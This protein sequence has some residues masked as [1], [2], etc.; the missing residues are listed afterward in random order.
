MSSYREPS[1]GRCGTSIATGIGLHSAGLHDRVRGGSLAFCEPVELGVWTIAN[2][3]AGST[4]CARRAPVLGWPLVTAGDTAEQLANAHS[5]LAAAAAHAEQLQRALVSNRQIGM[6]MGILM[7]RHKL[8]HEQAFDR[9]RDLSQ[10]SN[11]K[12]HD[13]AEQIIYTGDPQ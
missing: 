9:L 4:S 11:V 3:V 10:R 13:V 1:T 2:F 5:D 6:A 12:L 8:T 7:E